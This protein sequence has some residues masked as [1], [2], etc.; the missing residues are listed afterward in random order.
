M[1][2]EDGGICKQLAERG[3]Y[4][5]KHQR[6]YEEEIA[7]A[8]SHPEKWVPVTWCVGGKVHRDL[9]YQP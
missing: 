1:W 6:Q 7:E 2:I 8:V 4:C 9:V 5:E 3:L